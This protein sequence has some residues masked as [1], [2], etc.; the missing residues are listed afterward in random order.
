[1]TMKKLFC[2]LIALSFVFV[3]NTSGQNATVEIPDVV[4]KSGNIEVPLNVDFTLDEVCGFNFYI[5]FNEDHL[6]FKGIDNDQL[7]N[8]FSSPADWSSPIS[9]IWAADIDNNP[10]DFEGKLLDLL[11][12]YDGGNANIWFDLDDPNNFSA[13]ADCEDTVDYEDVIFTHGS[14]SLAPPVPLSTWAIIAGLG[15]MAAFV[16]IKRGKLF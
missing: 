1:M 5:H 6:T 8:I 14:V 2:L 4:S 9:I 10:A 16:I 12:E 7:D 15:L 3:S 13:V 11:F